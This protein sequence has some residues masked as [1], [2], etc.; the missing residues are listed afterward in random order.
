MNIKFNEF[1]PDFQQI[2][3]KNDLINIQEVDPSIKV[4]LVFA[5]ENNIAGIN[6]YGELSKCYLHREFAFKL[7]LAHDHLKEQFPEYR[8]LVIDGT[9]PKRVSK[10]L[11]HHF[12]DTP[13]QNYVA[14]PEPGSAHNFGA[15]VDLTILNEQGTQLDMGCPIHHLGELAEPK[16]EDYFLSQGIL[17]SK[18]LSNRLLLRNVMEEAG[19]YSVSIEWWHFNGLPKEDILR[20]YKIIE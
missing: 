17:T 12:K 3:I 9:R 19:F 4:D 14:N 7:Q 20:M 16:R 6:F 2:F 5:S 1:N 18:H 11:W 10:M 8:F 15:A 13:E